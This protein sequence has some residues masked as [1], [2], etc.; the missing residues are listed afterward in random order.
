MAWASFVKES[1]LKSGC[2]AWVFFFTCWSPSVFLCPCWV[3]SPS[4][5]QTNAFKIQIRSRSSPPP[6]YPPR[7]LLVLYC[8]VNQ[9]WVLVVASRFLDTLISGC[10]FPLH[11]LLSFLFIIS[12]LF[13]CSFLKVANNFIP[14]MYYFLFLGCFPFMCG[15][16]LI[17]HVSAQIRKLF[18]DFLKRAPLAPVVIH[19]SKYAYCHWIKRFCHIEPSARGKVGAGSPSAMYSLLFPS[20]APEGSWIF[21]Y[22]IRW[23]NML[24]ICR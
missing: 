4:G 20:F 2:L 16:L 15:K 3:W 14:F 11:L 21:M 10:F 7:L 22:I 13:G 23:T 18:L 8:N 1:G 5:S 9:C 12:S 17:T 24:N 19:F 6:P